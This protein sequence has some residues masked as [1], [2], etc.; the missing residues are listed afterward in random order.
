VGIPDHVGGQYGG[1]ATLHS[2][3]PWVGRLAVGRPKIHMLR[4]AR[5]V[6]SW[7]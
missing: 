5:N 4:K 1:E 6:G 3:F 2:W 7:L